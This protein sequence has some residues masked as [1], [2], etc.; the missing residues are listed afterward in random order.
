[1]PYDVIEIFLETPA[2]AN[3]A[4]FIK[5]ISKEQGLCRKQIWQIWQMWQA[6]HICPIRQQAMRQYIEQDKRIPLQAVNMANLANPTNVT[7]SPKLICTQATRQF[8]RLEGSLHRR[9]IWQIWQMWQ[10]RQ[11]HQIRQI[12]QAW[13]IHQIHQQATRQYT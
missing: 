5:L 7:N 9:P 10:A 13:Q 3:L 8:I 4:K 2:T 11:I 6:W 1:M 12:W